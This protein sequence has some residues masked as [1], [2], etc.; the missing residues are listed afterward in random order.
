MTYL[1][2]WIPYLLGIMLL[3]PFLFPLTK[4]G[5][6][7]FLLLFIGIW[8]FVK[9]TKIKQFAFFLF[10]F[11]FLLRFLAILLIDTPIVSDFKTMFEAAIEINRGNLAL[12]QSSSYFSLW[13]YQFGHTLYMSLFLKL[14][15]N[16]FFLKFLNALFS[17]GSIVLLYLI[18]KDFV[19]ERTARFLCLLYSFFPFSLLLNT[20]LTNQHHSTFFCLLAL[21]F[22]IGKKFEK[23]SPIKKGIL[24]GSMLAISQILRPEG[25]VFLVALLVYILLTLKKKEEKKSFLLLAFIFLVYFALTTSTSFLLQKAKISETG[26]KNNDF[27]WKFVTGLN[28]KTNGQYSEEDALI[29][30]FGQKK[31]GLAFLKR[32]IS[33]D[34]TKY[35]TLFLKKETILW[36][37]SDLSWSI[38]HFPEKGKTELYQFLTS[39][40]QIFLFFFVAIGIIGCFC[41]EKRKEFLFLILFLGAYFG[42][43]LFIEIMPRYAYTPQMILLL[44]GMIG[45]EQIEKQFKEKKA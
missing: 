12:V 11:S 10:I 6:I 13:S 23:I 21:Y 43:Y 41:K 19:K 4:I 40:N 14:I 26:L 3:F 27:Y 29:Y 24:V 16:V 9:K 36:M 42:V 39:F 35:P 8:F 25:I 31:E 44:I 5:I 45:F 15:P 33:Q 32:R 34:L 37:Q 20:V 22:L 1:K 38:G 30:P 17:S 7:P 28:V 2:R 18:G